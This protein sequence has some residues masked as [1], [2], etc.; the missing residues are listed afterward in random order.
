MLIFLLVLLEGVNL[1]Y[2]HKIYHLAAKL[3][4]AGPVYR[5]RFTV[6]N[7]KIDVPRGS[8]NILKIFSEAKDPPECGILPKL[9]RDEKIENRSLEVIQRSGEFTGRGGGIV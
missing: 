8:E 1:E 6:L 9:S 3:S 5:N 4:I 2:M 7:S